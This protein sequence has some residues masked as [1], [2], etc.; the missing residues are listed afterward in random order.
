MFD[1]WPAMGPTTFQQILPVVALDKGVIP[2]VPIGGHFKYLGRVFDFAVKDDVPKNEIDDR[3]RAILNTITDLNVKI[4]T[5][6]KIFS[7]Y[8]P[9]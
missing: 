9:S 8:I 2:A 4:Q 5:K 7:K 3:I 6:L 1:L